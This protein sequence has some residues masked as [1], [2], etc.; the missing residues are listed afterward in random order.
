[1]ANGVM[2]MTFV[3]TMIREQYDF[4]RPCDAR[5]PLVSF[6]VAIGY[7][8]TNLKLNLN[9]QHDDEGCRYQSSAD[10]PRQ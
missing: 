7:E 10:T 5:C 2:K 3:W 8:K 9:L 4:L 1:M 6:N